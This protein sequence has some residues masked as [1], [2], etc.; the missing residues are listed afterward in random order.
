MYSS[1]ATVVSASGQGQRKSILAS[2]MKTK[3]HGALT[4]CHD[5]CMDLFMSSSQPPYE[6][7]FITLPVIMEKKTEVTHSGLDTCSLAVE[8]GVLTF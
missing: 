3:Y 6:L 4:V 5:F 7:Q 8:S 1:L 2:V